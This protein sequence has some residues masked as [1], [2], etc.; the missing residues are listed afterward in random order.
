LPHYRE[1]LLRRFFLISLLCLS[2]AWSQEPSGGSAGAVSDWGSCKVDLPPPM[3]M[4]DGAVPDDELEIVSGKVEFQWQGDAKFTD[5]IILRSGNRLLRADGAR[6]DNETGIFAV[7]GAVEFRDPDTRVQADSAEFNRNTEEVRFEAAEFQFWAVPARGSA[8]QIRV[9]RAGQLELTK[10]SYTSCPEGKDDWMLRARKIHVDQTTGVGTA[11]N[12][13]LEFK[14]VPILYFPWLSYPVTNQRK[15]GWLIPDLG[16]SQKRGLDIALPFYWNIA[17]TYD[18]TITPRYMS[19]RGLQMGGDFRYLAEDHNGIMSGEYLND[20]DE[21]GEDRSLVAWFHQ[22]NFLP[23]W[24]GTIDAAQVSDDNYFEDLGSNLADTSQPNLRQRMDIEFYNNVWSGLLRFQD[25][26]TLDPAITADDEPYKQLPSLA[27]R[28]FSPQGLFGLQYALDGEATYFERS[29]GVTGVRTHVMPEVALPIQ[30]QF[31]EL[32][33]AVA[34][35]YTRYNL[36]DT[37]AGT[38]ENPDRSLPI[39]SFDVSSVFERATKG[40]RWLQT[41]EP[42]LM[43]AYIPFENQDDLPVF[44]TI[45]PDLNVVQAFRKN[46]FVGLDRLGDTNQLSIGIDTRMIDATKGDEVLRGTIGHIRY[47]SDR[48]VTLP[49]G[50]PSDSNSSDYLAELGLRMFERWRMRLGFQWNSD[51][52]ETKKAEARLQYRSGDKRIANIAYRFRRDTLQEI[53]LALAWP[54]GNRWNAVGRYNYSMEDNSLLEGLVGVEYETCCW[55]VRSV[56]R[57]YIASRDGNFDTSISLQLI[58][59]G[60][61]SRDSAAE[62]ILDRGILGYD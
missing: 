54:L 13:K 57:R 18:A 49:G 38:D 43:Y 31:L 53:D 11:R 33:P 61:G 19:K 47:F 23:N 12:A 17:P 26:Q 9:E 35:D 27:I 52:S 2:S 50:A 29:V 24:R 16:S 20:D 56:W 46:R 45:T 60:F 3:V 39:Y 28:G 30:G 55:A 14:G 41:L 42:H 58:L 8:K 34:F 37:P 1:I 6:F 4:P 36:N 32:K 21:T 10:V 25:Y 22:A 40:Q 48:E 59:K 62:D 51:D 5:E 7:D 44:D 15:T